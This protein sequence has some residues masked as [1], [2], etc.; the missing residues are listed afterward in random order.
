MLDSDYF[1]PAPFDAIFKASR[2]APS[3]VHQV[4]KVYQVHKSNFLLDEPDELEKLDNSLNASSLLK[5]V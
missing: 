2:M 3:K 1:L 5:I 4:H